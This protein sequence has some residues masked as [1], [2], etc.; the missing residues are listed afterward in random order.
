MKSVSSPFAQCFASLFILLSAAD[1]HA[2]GAQRPLYPPA[3]PPFFTLVR[4]GRPEA[5]VVVQDKASVEERHAAAELVNYVRRISGAKLE[6]AGSAGDRPAVILRVDP[7]L[8]PAPE[9]ERD[10][11]GSRGYRLLV[12]Q[13]RLHVIG[14]D[15]LSVLLGV[16]GLLE[17]HLDVRWLWPGEL[18]EVVPQQKTVRVGQLD[19]TSVPDFRVRWVGTGDWALRHGANTMVRIGSQPVG[20]RWKWH[21]HTFATL[22]PAEKYFDRHP[23]WW[24]LV[25][26]KRQ[27]P[28][29]DHS[30]STQLCTSNP[31]LVAE[32]TRNLIAVLDKEPDTQIIALSPNDGGG[33]C[34]CEKCRA[35]DEPGRDWFARYSKRLA[36]LNNAV[37]REVAKR[38][39]EVLIK[40]GAYAMYLRRPLDEDLAPTSN[41]LVQIC[42]IYCC[43]NHTIQG[44]RCTPGK[45]YQPSG[46]FMPNAEFRKMLAD[47]KKVTDHL[48][49]Y[50]YYT[51][52]G[53]TRA[54]LPW[55]LA[56]ALRRDMPYYHKIGAEGFYT[57][58]GDAT[59]HRYGMNY[60]LAAKLAWNARLD[61]DAL[62][63]DYCRHAFGGGADA[64]LGYFRRMEQAMVDSDRCLSYGLESPKRWGPE[65]FTDQVMK[66]AGALLDRALGAAPPG[67]CRRRVEFF[68][69]GFEESRRAL[70]GMRA[71]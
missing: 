61:V 28:T 7:A 62:M 35:L 29:R 54:E 11:A 13:N 67:P 42:H 58:L 43:H 8:N 37:A 55:P 18:G 24:P 66:E 5:V 31:E 27:R 15:P 2:G 64:M 53:P 44:G 51:L 57:Q 56:H 69:K 63:A 3:K 36:V 65:V 49:I 4:D 41:Q 33:F 71:K 22:I 25:K 6:V 17:R 59:F 48:F 34:E 1:A 46:R 16:Y 70:A 14:S 60:Y 40:I 50:E 68:Q 9:G 23:E 39:P 47:W 32:M 21:F 52:G 20:V 19:E 45:T 26:G 12:E 10:W 38:H 30:H